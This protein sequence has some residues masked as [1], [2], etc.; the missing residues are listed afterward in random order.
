M[1]SLLLAQKILSLFIMIAMGFALVKSGVVKARDSWG[2]SNV[3]L[4]IVSPCC[5][6]AAFQ[7]DLTDD[8]RTGF[9]LALGAAVVIQTG[10]LF[11]SWLA[12]RTLKF[13]AVEKASAAYP[14]AGNLI[15]PLV[16]G[17][18]GSEWVIYCTAFMAFQTM[19]LWSH[20]RSLLM[21]T[22]GID[23]RAIVTNVNMVAIAAGLVLFFTGLRFPAPVADAIAGIG[24]MIG[25]LSMLIIG[26]VMGSMDF[27][28]L[29]SFKRLPL[30]VGARLVAFP[31]VALVFLKFTGFTALSPIGGQIAVIVLLAAAA[32]S[33]ST[34][35]QMAQIYHHNAKYAN[36]I[37]VA[38]ILLCIATMPLMVALFQM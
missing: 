6:I 22:S 2:I 16:A 8:V 14:N 9:L 30:V 28:S 4:Y 37:N 21:G 24:Q 38:S 29:K 31:L 1:L 20:A 18:F 17:L 7:V 13:D 34:I 15:I 25:P 12:G 36:A 27:A 26:M 33:A 5:I 10:Y 3:V 32:P 23:W 35:S 19:L 11:L